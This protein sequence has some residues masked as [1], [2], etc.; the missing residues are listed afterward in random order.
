MSGYVF[1]SYAREDRE[2][3]EKLAT[4][5]RGEGIDVWYD[6]QLV[7]GRR[8]DN[9]LPQKIEQCAA[10]ILVM[11]PASNDSAWVHDEFDLAKEADRDL[12]P[13][14]LDGKKFFGIGKIHCEYLQGGE[15]PS[16]QFVLVL[17]GL[18][19]EGELLF[20]M[21]AHEGQVR[22]VAYPASN[23]SMVASAG[24]EMCVRIW[25]PTTGQ[26]LQAIRGATWP[27]SFSRHGDKIATGG[28]GHT[29]HV[30]DTETGKLIK[31]VGEHKKALTSVAVSPDGTL[32]VTG[33]A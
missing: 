5:L 16:S 13:I 4:F 22:S 20:E 9:A 29:V 32:L 12:M 30:W 7:P 11:T 19:G 10:F 27:V 15:L 26:L 2:Y 21:K 33:S 14:L 23:P 25:D 6:A 17:R 28:P 24:P 31:Q 1:I 8:F 3:V 18:V